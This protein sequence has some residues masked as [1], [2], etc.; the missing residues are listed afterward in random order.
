MQGRN[1][2]A[3]KCRGTHGTQASGGFLCGGK[4]RENAKHRGAASTHGSRCSCTVKKAQQRADSG[5]R[6]GNNALKT[7]E[8]PCGYHLYITQPQAVKQPLR[9]TG[10][11][12]IHK[13]IEMTVKYAECNRRAD[14]LSLQ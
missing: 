7:I 11:M 12:K 1:R 14:A 5:T 4:I 13:I 8:Q 9:I 10:R 6:I 3:G 2:R